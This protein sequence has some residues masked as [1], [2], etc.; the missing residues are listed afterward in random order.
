MKSKIFMISM[1]LMAAMA[2]TSSCIGNTQNDEAAHAHGMMP[3][4]TSDDSIYFK[5]D[6][7]PKTESEVSLI[8]FLS[9]KFCDP[10]DSVGGGKTGIVFVVVNMVVEKDGTPTHF[11][12]IGDS[13]A[14]QLDYRALRNAKELPKFTPA[15]KDG[16]IVR[17][18]FC[19]AVPYRMD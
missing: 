11:E 5:P 15:Q 9:D 14:P 1:L 4:D 17:S 10:Q 2:G 6:V 18:T 19:T 16:K 12:V 7:L 8:H 3:Q 13:T